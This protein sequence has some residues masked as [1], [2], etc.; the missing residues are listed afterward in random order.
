M[1]PKAI[2]LA[3]QCLVAEDPA[4]AS[5]DRPLCQKCGAFNK[6][7]V[8]FMK[9]QVPAKWT[10][11]LLIV[12]ERPGQDEDQKSG[13]PFSGPSGK[14]LRQ[15]LREAGFEYDEVAFTNATRCADPKNATPTTEQIRCCRPFLLWE[16]ERLN[17]Q[18]VLGVGAKAGVALTNDGG[19]TVKGTRGRV[20]VVPGL[21]VRKD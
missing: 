5:P 13:Y 16:L 11:R 6:A 4:T 3:K 21:P 7:R 20:L 10:G 8:P 9:A 2:P 19:L 15:M 12:G 1:K 18:R 14:L 17:P